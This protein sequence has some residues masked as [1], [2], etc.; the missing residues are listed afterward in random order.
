MA[1]FS[2]MR[3]TEASSTPG[4]RASALCTRAWQAAQVI[5]VTG[6]RIDSRRAGACA[7]ATCASCALMTG[8]L[9]VLFT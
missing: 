5:P 2:I 3:F 4:C 8:V 6:M 7:L 1:A 9:E